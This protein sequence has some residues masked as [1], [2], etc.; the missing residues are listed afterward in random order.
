MVLHHFASADLALFLAP[1]CDRYSHGN[2]NFCD[3]VMRLSLLTLEEK[4]VV[5]EFTERMK[6]LWLSSSLKEE[7]LNYTN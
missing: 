1:P 6:G 4:S 5:S 7:D 3:S 2:L